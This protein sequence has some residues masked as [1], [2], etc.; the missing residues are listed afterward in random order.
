[1]RRL[2][3]VLAPPEVWEGNGLLLGFGFANDKFHLVILAPSREVKGDALKLDAYV[4]VFGDPQEQW[5][6]VECPM[7]LPSGALLFRSPRWFGE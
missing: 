4:L 5:V 3:F 2:R 1:L 7:K 6:L